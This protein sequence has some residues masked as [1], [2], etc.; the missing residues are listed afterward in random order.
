MR[1][2][3]LG[4]ALKAFFKKS[5]RHLLMW[6]IF[7][8]KQSRERVVTSAMAPLREA[9]VSRI[10]KV[11]EGKSVCKSSRNYIRTMTCVSEKVG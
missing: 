6:P 7:P 4:H 10:E 5:L 8:S 2:C 11:G 9:F 3:S 1:R